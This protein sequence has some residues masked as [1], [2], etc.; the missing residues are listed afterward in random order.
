MVL[1]NWAHVG[2]PRGHSKGSCASQ[3]P[4]KIINRYLKGAT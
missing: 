3:V 4:A 1:L 2:K